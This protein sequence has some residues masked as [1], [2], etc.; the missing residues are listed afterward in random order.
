MRTEHNS[1][2][3]IESSGS[4]IR[5]SRSRCCPLEAGDLTNSIPASQAASPLLN[6]LIGWMLYPFGDLIAQLIIGHVDFLRVAIVML[7]G[8]LVYRLEIPAWFRRIDEFSLS[9]TTLARLPW[10]ESVI[11]PA[12]GTVSR[13]LNWFGRTVGAI[14]YF[15]PL[16]IA[17]HQFFISLTTIGAGSGLTLLGS[18]FMTGGVSFLTNLP[19]SLLFNYLI[20]QH[21]HMR[22]RLLASALTTMLFTIKYALELRLLQ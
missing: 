10:L 14:I 6:H 3:K 21:L 20:Q 13:G 22:F 11:K 18:S 9:T 5:P 8:G 12:D 1:I 17:R 19:L 7:L 2:D 16:W 15:N 4:H